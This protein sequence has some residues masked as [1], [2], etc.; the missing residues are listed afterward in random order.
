MITREQEIWLAHLDD[1]NSIEIFPYDTEAG[2]KFKRIKKLLVSVLGEGNN[3]I[4]RGASSLGISGQKEIDIYIPVAVEMFNSMLPALEQVFGIPR[5]HYPLERACY[6]A[7]VDGTKVEIFVINN[8]SKG[9]LDGLI[10]ETYLKENRDS[11]DEYQT[12]KEKSAGLST[13]K[14]YYKK[15]EFI[16]DV[17]IKALDIKSTI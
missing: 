6:V 1:T 17:L 7:T 10:F 9:W 15:I 2:D 16:N 5:S 14:Y 8:Q 11:L 13:Q 12:L 3:I 4:H